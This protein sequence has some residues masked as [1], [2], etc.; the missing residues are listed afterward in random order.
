MTGNSDYHFVLLRDVF[1]L[2]VDSSRKHF[3]LPVIGM[4][5]I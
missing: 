1:T 3:F 5:G 2:V 4:V